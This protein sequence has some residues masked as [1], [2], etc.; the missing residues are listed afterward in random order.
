[1]KLFRVS[2]ASIYKWDKKI[3]T[4]YVIQPDKNEA[5]AYVNRTKNAIFEI[6]KVCY[7]G[8]ELSAS[9]FKGGKEE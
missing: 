6:K 2:M 9:M 1:M 3:R 8:Y 5:I 4:L 7:L